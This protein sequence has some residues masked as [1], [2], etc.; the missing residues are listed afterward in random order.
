M[1]LFPL[2]AVRLGPGPFADAVRTD[3]AYVL[4]LDTDRLLAPLLAESGLTPAAPPYGNWESAAI[5]GHTL[6]H[7]LSALAALAAALGSR[8]ARERLDRTVAEV[9]RAQDAVGTGYVGG[10][11]GGA[12][13]FEA[14][15][16][17]G[18]AAARELGSSAHWVPWYNLHKTFQ[19]LLDAHRT[20]GNAQ[21]LQVVTR[22]ADWWL[23]VAATM[24]DAAFQ[25]MLDTEHGAMNDVFATLSTLTGRADHAAMARRFT[26]RA[27]LGP[28]AEGRDALTG[29]HANT[30]IPKVLGFAGTAAVS[31]PGSG[32]HEAADTFWRTVVERRTVAIGGNSVREHFHDP[33]DFTPV[34]DERE[35]PEF[36]NT[37]HMLRLTAALNRLGTRPE[38]LDYAERA[39]FNHV[40]SAQHPDGGF[41]YFTPMR[42]RHYRVYSTPHSCFWCCVGTGMEAQARYGEWVFGTEGDTVAV[43]LPVAAEV[44]LPGGGTLRLD[45]DVPRDDRVRLRLD[46]PAPR[47]FPLRLRVPSWCDDLVDLEVDGAPVRDARRSPGAVH[48]DRAWA[49]G[50]VVTYRLPMRLR[51]ERLPDGS[52]WQ[53]YA[54]GPTVLA[55]RDG[56]AHL[57]GLFADDA[58]WG[59]VA[60]GPLV[61]LADLPLV[62]DGTAGVEATGPLRFRVRPVDGEPFELEP[63]AGVHGTRYTVYWP[64]AEGDVAARRAALLDLDAGAAVDDITLDRVAFGEQQ[65]EA[66]HGLRASASDVGVAGALRWRTT[67]DRMAV[68]LRDPEGRAVS[69]RVGVRQ[70]DVPTAAEIRVAGAVV[71]TVRLEAGGAT[72]DVVRPVLAELTAAGRPADVEL[73]VVAVDDRPTPGIT[74][75]RLLRWQA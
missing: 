58:R 70:L 75:V 19:G 52:P 12:A 39:L 69:L 17:G 44:D 25:A 63:F 68:T 27:L 5:A 6:G 15:R 2:S 3:L 47:A 64:V 16:H 46:L 36:C 40:L 51:A 74:T 32:L 23:D 33:D 10:V 62:A 14:L 9:A 73:E 48:L 20:G 49:P 35:G 54:F 1:E 38:Y 53:A 11:P 65:P 66:D 43:N 34:I 60:H 26:H 57:E 22:F 31:E 4:E 72:S 8:E 18:V 42:P 37:F 24:D 50:T 56:D 55:A 7:H 28:L 59:H 41:V 13:L 29:L 67:R 71:A 45:A 61:S 21:A 30:Q